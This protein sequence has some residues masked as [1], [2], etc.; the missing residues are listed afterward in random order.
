MGTRFVATHE[1]IA[2]LGF[3]QR[4]VEATDTETVIT[5]RKISPTR[6]LKGE[7]TGKLL[8]MESRGAEASELQSFIGPSRSRKGSLEGDLKNGEAYCGAVAGMIQEVI[9]AAEVIRNIVDGYSRVV[10]QL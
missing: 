8:E 2:H 1:C 10:A 4:I 6:A 7:F 3:K 9:G 5:G